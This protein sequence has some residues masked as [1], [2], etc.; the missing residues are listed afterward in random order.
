M[1]S[2]AGDLMLALGDLLRS[3]A[4]SALSFWK[5]VPYKEDTCPE[6]ILS[7]E[8]PS[9]GED[10]NSHSVRCLPRPGVDGPGLGL[11]VRLCVTAERGVGSGALAVVLL[12]GQAWGRWQGAQAWQEGAREGNVGPKKEAGR[13]LTY[14][15]VRRPTCM[16]QLSRA[17]RRTNHGDRSRKTEDR[18]PFGTVQG[19]EHT[20]PDPGRQHPVTP[21]F[22]TA[23]ERDPGR[24]STGDGHGPSPG[25]GGGAGRLGGGRASQPGDES[26]VEEACQ[27]WGRQR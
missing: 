26:N 5:M 15:A 24:A 16:H 12:T 22:R 4:T 14:S 10:E 19:E 18:G 7:C 20:G 2:M 1:E 17:G 27:L 23:R 8:K 9:R 3:W 11:M 25:G 13:P 6:G 21:A